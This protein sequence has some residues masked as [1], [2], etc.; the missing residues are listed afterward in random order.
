M[1]K[2]RHY[3]YHL[4]SVIALVV[5]LIGA[6]V[7]FGKFLNWFLDWGAVK[8]MLGRIKDSE[9]ESVLFMVFLLIV[10]KAVSFSLFRKDSSTEGKEATSKH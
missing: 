6:Y 2:A 4:T 7:S 5:S 3:A 8:A 1:A 9:V 10:L